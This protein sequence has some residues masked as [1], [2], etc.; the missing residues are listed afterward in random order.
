MENEKRL[1]SIKEISDEIEK[2]RRQN[3]NG[4]QVKFL[5]AFSELDYS[6]ELTAKAVWGTQGKMD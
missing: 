6:M 2:R 5:S 3:H 1:G 4:Q